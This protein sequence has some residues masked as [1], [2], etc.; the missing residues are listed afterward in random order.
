MADETCVEVNCCPLGYTVLG[1][2][3]T[4]PLAGDDSTATDPNIADGQLVLAEEAAWVRCSISTGSLSTLT[5]VSTPPT[6]P[7]AKTNF[8]DVQIG[9]FAFAV[10]IFK[11]F[12]CTLG[13]PVIT[14]NSTTGVSAGDI[15]EFVTGYF[16]YGTTVLSTSSPNITLSSNA[17]GSTPVG[18]TDTLISFRPKTG[19]V[20]IGGLPLIPA[21]TVVSSWSLSSVTLSNPTIAPSAMSRIVV[22]FYPAEIDPNVTDEDELFT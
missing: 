14:V 15:I 17:L 9:Y 22:A 10:S 12:T 8:E 13:S 18:F 4:L 16:P 11:T 19:Q 3:G 21:G 6:L 1:L 7:F 20:K 5:S 2:G